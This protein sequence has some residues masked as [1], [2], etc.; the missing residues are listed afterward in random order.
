MATAPLLPVI[1]YTSR[2]Y[3]SIRSDIIR[4]IQA[5]IPTWTAD[6]PSDFGVAL[7]EGIAYAVD[8]LHYYLD[9]V[10]NEAYLSTAVQ[11][12]SLYSIADMFNYSPRRATPSRV[13]LTFVNATQATVTL[14]AGTRV[15]ASV[16]GQGGAI[17]KNFE[18]QEETVIPASEGF[19][20]GEGKALS[21]YALEG[22]TYTDETI[23][24]SNG[25]VGQT[26]FLPR[27][28]VLED[29]IQITTQVGDVITS[30]S[31]VPSLAEYAD[32][33]DKSFEAMTQ[34]DGSCV[35]RF[36]D[37]LNGDVPGLHGIIRAT[38]RVGGGTSGN[39][40]AN[41]I[42][43]IIEPVLYGVSVTNELAAT[44]GT[45]AE[46]LASIRVNAARSY[47]A[48]GRAVTLAD[49]EAIV[50]TGVPDIAKSKAIG[51]SGSSV[52]VYVA[53]VDDGTGMPVLTA[54]QDLAATT[55]LEDRAMA[56]VT[57][58]VFGAS[59][60]PI[61]MKIDVHCLPTARQDEV[62]QAVR[63]RLDSLFRYQNVDFNQT[64]TVQTLYSQ[65]IGITGLDY[66][67]I[68]QLSLAFTDPDIEVI[69]LNG[70]A[71]N[72]IPFFK[73]DATVDRPG[74]PGQKD[75]LLTLTPH[76]GINPA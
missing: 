51:N 76:G 14:P 11:R 58:Q 10:A 20:G 5:R 33:T 1:D 49:Y 70:T 60:I 46:S 45:N 41:V 39:V 28:S 21:V 57:V 17:L 40:P 22:R 75:P 26:F 37:G 23:G 72:A 69:D 30:W 3:E 31:E 59:F 50:I 2:D 8:G 52:T 13:Y 9:R 29:T 7:V 34:T 65:L 47:R 38:Y 62:M 27:T 74:V 35:I 32:P 36:G 68:T 71:V 53:P 25:F 4:L 24:V 73:S 19:A 64:V 54:N 55:Y 15:Q 44:G 16:P 67:S 66:A 48:R 42:N 18:V 6:N 12:E 63:G 56:G 61:F 43:T